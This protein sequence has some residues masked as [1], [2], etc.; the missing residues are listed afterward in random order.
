[1]FQNI[2]LEKAEDG[3]TVHLW[4]DQVGYSMFPY[5][6][7]DYAYKITDKGTTRSLLGQTVKKV[8]RWRREDLNVIESDLP[9]ETRV[10]TD[11]YLESDEPSKGHCLAILDI[12]AD[13]ETGLPDI[14]T[15]DKEITSI[16]LED[17]IT[18]DEYV[19][20]L[21]EDGELD[22]YDDEEN[23]HVIVFNAHSEE[24]LLGDFLD[25][26]EQM[27]PTMVTGWNID[28]FDIPYLY[29]RICSVLGSDEASRLSP[30]GL[31]RFM[32]RRAKYQIAGV[33]ALDYLDL[34]KKFTYTEQPNY[35]LDTIAKAELK[36][37][38]YVYEGTLA[39][40]RRNNIKGF[41]EYNLNDVRLVSGLDDKMKL[42]QLVM[43][44]C[45][46]GHVPYEEYVFSSRW[47]EGALIT[48]L[49]RKGIVCPNKSPSAKEDMDEKDKSGDK[50]FAGAYVKEP[51]AGRHEW[52]FSLDLQ[53]LYPSI[54][55]SLN[56]SPETK[57]GKVLNWN[58]E[59]H[60]RNEISEYR[61]QDNEEKETLVDR[62]EFVTFM[63]NGKFSL[64][65][66]GIIYR[67]DNVGMIPEILDRWFGERLEYKKLQ[68][69]AAHAGNDE[70]EEYWD[71]RQHIQK[72]FL[73]SLYG[74]L[75][76]P[77]F[78]F[79]DLDNALAV[80]A[81]GQDV[82]KTSAR[83]IN[84]EY[85]GLLDTEDEDYCIYID[86]DSLYFS[87]VPFGGG[88]DKAIEMARAAA[89]KLN[90]FYNRM[91]KQLFFIPGRH[92]FV[93]KGETIASAAFWVTKKRYAMKKVYDLETNMDADKITI[94]GLDVV[95]SSFPTAFRGFMKEVLVDILDDVPKEELDAKIL[96][97]YNSLPQIPIT[98]VARNTAV[99]NISKYSVTDQRLGEYVLKTPAHV[100]AAL[101]HNLLLREWNIHLMYAAITNGVKIKWVYLKDNPYKVPSV[102]FFGD[103]DAPQISKLVEEFIDYD[104]LFEKEFAHKLQ[105]FYKALKWGKIPTQVN[106][107]AQEFFVL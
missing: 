94:K 99:K 87:V 71:M 49:H 30:I 96:A 59:A 20:I 4:D 41:L 55:M 106:Q 44:I 75:G 105:D 40:L 78:R 7:F 11:L 17:K 70:Q 23:E 51:I 81:T 46:V 103:T 92:R 15:A 29:K 62:E 26:W 104:K 98:D 80:T 60:V 85:N 77:I 36:K 58:L 42:I 16:A 93:I 22:D 107:K 83:V 74:V 48:F 12:E 89:S 21:D 38:K 84:M 32:D 33:A 9:R 3:M 19:F 34:Y 28:Y 13:T 100:K 97:F 50:G 57:I 43:G 54:I 25:I 66:N 91:A 27:H 63:K 79:Y 65:S 88:K 82:I 5:K 64:S 10:L 45:T 67:T 24:E 47:L 102:A 8:Q 6:D 68:K 14:L 31:V 86:T 53:S 90:K 37:G 76:L 52:V 72:I 69:E 2:Y 95:R 73:N 18:G 56:I 101:N 1:V 39:E 61:I 35:R